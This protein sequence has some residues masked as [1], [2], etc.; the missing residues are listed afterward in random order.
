MD[1]KK[2]NNKKSI[3]RKEFDPKKYINTEPRLN[4]AK[5][6]DLAVISFGRM[7]PITI[8]H[9]KLVNKIISIAGK[10]NATPMI[11]LS[12]SNDAKKNPLTYDQK[13][14]Y[15]QRAF[16]IIIT[17]S[18]AKTPIQVLVELQSKYKNII[19]VAGSDRVDA[20]DDL[21]NNYNG[22]DYTYDSIEVVSAGE[23]DPDAEGVSGVSASKMRALA[24]DNN[25]EE[26]TKGLPRKLQSSAEEILVTIRK[27]M[28][29][30]EEVIY[31][32]LTNAQ[33]RKRAIIMRKA[34]PKIK[35]GRERAAKKLATGSKLKDRARKQA[36]NVMKDKFAKEK[37][38]SELGYA[39][40][41]QIDDKIKKM[42]TSKIDNLA[43]KLLPSVKKKEKERFSNRTKKENINIAFENF[44]EEREISEGCTDISKV[45]KRPHLLLTKDG[46]VKYDKRFKMYKARNKEVADIL[47][48]EQEVCESTGDGVL[49]FKD[50]IELAE[51]VED[52]VEVAKIACLK[53]DEV[54]T[55]KA[56]AKN[57]DVC[58]KC[59]KS[60]QG[61]AESLDEAIK[62]GSK[63]KVNNG[64]NKGKYGTVTAIEKDNVHV[65]FGG[66][67]SVNQGFGSTQ[68]YP[69]SY[70]VKSKYIE[71]SLDEAKGPTDKDVDLIIRTMK[72]FENGVQIM[73]AKYGLSRSKAQG[74]M[75]QRM[76][77]TKQNEAKGDK[78]YEKSFFG[79]GDSRTEKEIVD[80]V[81][82][83]TD[84]TLQIWAKDSVGRFGS[85]IA[86]LQSK[87]VADEMKK[88]GLSEAKKM[89]DDPCWDSHEM[90]GKKLKGGKLV[91]NCVPKESLDEAINKDSPLY[92]EYEGLK[93]K[94]VKD[95]RRIYQQNNRLDT[96]GMDL[97]GK[98]DI[99]ATILRDRHGTKRL[100]V[101]YNES[102]EESRPSL[103]ETK[104]IGTYVEI[105]KG[106]YKG[107]RGTIRSIRRG[108]YGNP[109]ARK[110]YL[111]LE[112]GNE[113]VAY[114]QETKVIK[115]IEES[116]EEKR[117]FDGAISFYA[118][119][120]S[121][122]LDKAIF[123]KNYEQ[124]LK[125]LFNMNAKNPKDF[126]RNLVKAAGV[127]DVNVRRLRNMY[128]E[129]KDKTQTESR[130]PGF[131]YS[132]LDIKN[133][134]IINVKL[135]RNAAQKIVNK[136]PQDYIM[137]S[138]DWIEDKFK[139][140]NEEGGA[141]DIGTNKLVNNYKDSTPGEGKKTFS[142]IK[143][144]FG[145][146][147]WSQNSLRNRER[148]T[149]LEKENDPNF[150]PIAN[151]KAK[152][153]FKLT[154]D[155]KVL[156][157]KAGDPMTWFTSDSAKKAARTM[158]NKSFNKGKQ[159]RL[160]T[161]SLNED[162]ANSESIIGLTNE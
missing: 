85:K 69:D 31:E 78:P 123:R 56:W 27:G 57:D 72:D 61:V 49:N 104:K 54:S 17:K 50:I 142:K 139:S 150:I 42:P 60:T 44:L 26:F 98:A 33:R 86:K 118:P 30:N 151:R 74:L 156:K 90:V 89:D 143:E 140:M 70:W 63:V 5:K 38:F 113:A 32:A 120:I 41:Q 58:P 153:V 158:M 96:S 13:I 66:K 55:A 148:N 132:V 16:G 152:S 68:D 92:K 11:F 62:I 157:N 134:K 149:G 47:D 23:R 59:K 126:S 29:I 3:S 131:R 161:E 94:S 112:D 15:A 159:F 107:K 2:P 129:I 115:R 14:K 109:T 81:K 102:L 43:K 76:K 9:E 141:G 137:G 37:S 82:G 101:L 125:T 105:T 119:T 106:P 87:L 46:A 114:S 28:N 53:C 136:N 19:F 39:Q 88:R 103:N 8:G 145:K 67:I 71:E 12:H 93:S 91:P 35:R 45:M 6:Q 21:L 127:W 51:S 128:D 110:F 138:S 64:R 24:V 77:D 40:R 10:E 146:G 99:I 95:L 4:E 79:V 25:L 34:A 147:R 100:K 135:T 22:K 144:S 7:N 162:D 122:F 73:D 160:V 121:K 130:K 80:Q 48:K 18:K 65:G 52:L 154:I 1:D 108:E 111:D 116:L 124:A 36:I 97:G 155:G 75:I 20:F 84:K 117:F 133:K 83:L